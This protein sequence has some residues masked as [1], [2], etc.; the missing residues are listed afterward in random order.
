[1]AAAAPSGADAALLSSRRLR[2]QSVR[3]GGAILGRLLTLYLRLARLPSLGPVVLDAD[4]ESAFERAAAELLAGGDARLPERRLDFVRW[5]AA[6]RGLAFHGSP[7]GGLERLE[8]IRRSRD[9]T[10]WGDQQALYATTD[11][12]WAIYFACLRRDAGFRGTRN[13]SMGRPGGPLYPRTYFFAHN[14]GAARDGRFGPG[15]LY[16]LPREPFREQPPLAGAVDTAHLVSTEAVVPL[17]RV[18]VTPADFPFAGR[19]ATYRD[20]EPIFVTLLRA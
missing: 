2:R 14:R 17:A 12:V 19:V 11:P 5:L 20:R 10:E 9:T 13:G 15:T 3:T 6:T 1:M 8:P 18:A 16:V 7:L 4:T